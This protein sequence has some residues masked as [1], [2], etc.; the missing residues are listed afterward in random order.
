VLP[1]VDPPRVSSVSNVDGAGIGAGTG[2]GVPPP[3]GI[4]AGMGAGAGA[5]PISDC[6]AATTSGGAP[7]CWRQATSGAA[8]APEPRIVSM[9]IEEGMFSV[10]MF[11]TE[12]QSMPAYADVGASSATSPSPDDEVNQRITSSPGRRGRHHRPP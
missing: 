1:N 7:R 12:S 6:A 4:G 3:T 8:M 5:P 9:T 2:I 10:T 11:I